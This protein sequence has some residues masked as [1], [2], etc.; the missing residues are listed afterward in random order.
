MRLV[1]K[2][3]VASG[4][5]AATA[6]QAYGVDGQADAKQVVFQDFAMQKDRDLNFGSAARGAVAKSIAASTNDVDSA[7]FTITG[8]ANDTYSVVVPADGTVKMVKSGTT[9]GTS[10]IEIDVNEFGF[11]SET[12]AS[13]A[14]G[15]LSAGGTDQLRIGA[16]RDP[17]DANEQP[18]NYSATFTVSVAH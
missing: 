15:Q 6:S 13:A 9:G 1:V 11:F 10:D 5:Y 17:I 7:Q 16:T 8:A 4:L 12:L 18:G 14:S 3:L 2:A